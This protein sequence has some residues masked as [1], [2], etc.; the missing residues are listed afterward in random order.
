MAAFAAERFGGV[1]VLC[2]NGG[3]FPNTALAEMT[4]ED[5]DGVLGCNLKGTIFAVQACLPA[6]EAS[7]RGRVVMTSSITGRSPGIP[8]GRAPGQQVRPAGFSADCR[9][10]AR[11]EADHHQRG[12]AGQHPHR[13]AGRDG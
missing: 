7:R 4:E 13:G 6:L 1:D 10:R 5:V 11:A 9:D 8:A 12:N 2:A 3:I